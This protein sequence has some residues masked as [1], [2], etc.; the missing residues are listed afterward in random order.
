MLFSQRRRYYCK[1]KK[2]TSI[3]RNFSNAA[4]LHI[5]Q[6]STFQK[7][8]L[9]FDE[10]KALRS[11]FSSSFS[12]TGVEISEGTGILIGRKISSPDTPSLQIVGSDTKGYIK[13]NEIISEGNGG[14]VP[15]NAI[16]FSNFT[17]LITLDVNYIQGYRDN[18]VVFINGANV[19]IKNA[20]I[21]NTYS[22][23]GVASVGIFLAGSQIITLSNVKVVTGSLTYGKTIYFAGVGIEVFNFGLFVNKEIETNITLLIGTGLGNPITYNYLYIVDPILT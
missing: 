4:A 7:L 12:T 23:S 13:C 21:K 20:L 6:G 22:G 5:A 14:N 10:V 15:V 19:Q 3:N 11:T 9:Y 2:I 18:G 8:V 17:N 1:N 16:D